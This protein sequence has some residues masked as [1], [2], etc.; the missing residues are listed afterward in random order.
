MTVIN[1]TIKKHWII[2]L[3]PGL[4]ILVALFFIYL[5]FG[6]VTKWISIGLLVFAAIVAISKI[7]KVLYI[8]SITWSFNGGELHVTKGFLPW[9]KTRIQIPIFDIYDSSVSIGFLGHYLNFGHIS[10]RRT[11]GI[12]SQFSERYLGSAVHFSGI[13][14]QYVQ[15]YKKG[16][17]PVS[18]N[19]GQVRD[20]GLELQRLVDLKNSGALTEDEYEKLKKKLINP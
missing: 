7:L 5:S 18:T 16:Q 8:A 19:H 4:I 14:N 10:I 13:V 1:L 6:I 2:Y 17:N 12:T 20:I 9:K 15:E 11:E 3:I